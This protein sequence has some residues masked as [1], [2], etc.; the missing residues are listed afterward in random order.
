MVFLGLLEMNLFE[1]FVDGRACVV[2]RGVAGRVASRVAGRV[3]GR[4]A[5]RVAGRVAGR[6]LRRRDHRRSLEHLCSH[7]VVC[8]RTLF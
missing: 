5:S 4:V 7:R 2:G 3:A 1:H 8:A 6:F